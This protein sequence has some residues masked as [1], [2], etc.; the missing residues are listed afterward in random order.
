MAAF[1]S[2]IRNFSYLNPQAI[3]ILTLTPLLKPTGLFLLLG[4]GLSVAL[5]AWVRGTALRKGTP[6]IATL[7]FPQAC[8]ITIGTPMRIRGVQVSH[9]PGSGAGGL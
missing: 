8:G 1:G 9:G 4:A 5:V 7:E 6:Y 2:G 3:L